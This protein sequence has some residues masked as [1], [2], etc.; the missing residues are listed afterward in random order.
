MPTLSTLRGTV[1]SQKKSKKSVMK[2][3]IH[4][5]LFA[6]TAIAYKKPA[7]QSSARHVK[8]AILV[9]VIV[10]YHSRGVWRVVTARGMERQTRRRYQQWR[11]R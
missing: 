8:V 11:R 4:R 10:P 6:L 2:I 9:A 1:S 5:G 7:G 3:A